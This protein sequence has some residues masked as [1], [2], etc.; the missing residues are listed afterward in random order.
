MEIEKLEKYL[1]TY[2]DDVISPNMNQELVGEEDEPIKMN[3][4]QI[5][6]G[7]YQPPIYH[8]FIDV[9]PNWDGS[10]RKKI[11]NDVNDFIKILSI[12]NRLKIHWNKR[13]AYKGSETP[14]PFYGAQEK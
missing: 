8:A 7:S 3:V 14:K 12:P 4:F 6:K 1:Q 5:L 9:E 13:P 2:L 10:Y 11:E